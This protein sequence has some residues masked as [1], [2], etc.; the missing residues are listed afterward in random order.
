M[1]AYKDKNTTSTVNHALELKEAGLGKKKIAF[2]DKKAGHDKVLE[3][4]EKEYPKLKSQ[5]G[6]FE[7]LRAGSGGNGRPISLLPPSA[8]GYTVPHIKN[9]VGS[10]TLI[11]IRQIQSDL[12][13]DKIAESSAFSPSIACQTCGG[14]FSFQAIS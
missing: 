3:T 2:Q 9:L 11:Y 14:K 10:S 7:L 4:L 12:L 5:N 8:E 6:R 13:L 1:L